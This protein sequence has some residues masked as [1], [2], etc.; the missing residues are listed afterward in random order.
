VLQRGSL[1]CVDGLLSV[2][3]GQNVLGV[4]HPI[5]DSLVLRLVLNFVNVFHAMVLSIEL[6]RSRISVSG[7]SILRWTATEASA[8]IAR[9]WPCIWA[10]IG[11]RAGFPRC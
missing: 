8:L 4:P 3:I 7:M 10:L 5:P 2:P 9:N 1:A 6:A 11:A